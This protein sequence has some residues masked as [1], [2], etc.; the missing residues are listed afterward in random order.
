MIKN[1]VSLEIAKL[2]KEKRYFKRGI[3][4]Y[5][6]RTSRYETFENPELIEY[7]FK[8]EGKDYFNK[9]KTTRNI[10]VNWSTYSHPYFIA[11]TIEML[12]SW[13]IKKK[14]INI[15]K[16]SEKEIIELIKSI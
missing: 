12:Q 4:P 16:Y 9:T 10:G 1:C 6:Y 15:E 14:N 3:V 2:L 8:I 7:G 11:P 13:L 5:I